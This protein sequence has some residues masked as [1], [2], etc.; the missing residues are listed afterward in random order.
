M[1]QLR[2]ASDVSFSQVVLVALDSC[3][4]TAEDSNARRV[5]LLHLLCCEPRRP[6]QVLHFFVIFVEHRLNG[7]LSDPLLELSWVIEMIFEEVLVPVTVLAVPLT[8]NEAYNLSNLFL[9]TAL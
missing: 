4:P 6:K 8:E 1:S 5:I 7:K 9:H 3:G 2:L